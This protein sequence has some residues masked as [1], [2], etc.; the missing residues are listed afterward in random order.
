MAGV[1]AGCTVNSYVIDNFKV[2]Q[3]GTDTA[4]LTYRAQQDTTCGAVHVPSPVWATSLFVRRAGRGQNALYVH[5]PAG[6]RY[7]SPPRQ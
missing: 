7:T 3:F 5:S 1:K 6:A 2:A 4:L